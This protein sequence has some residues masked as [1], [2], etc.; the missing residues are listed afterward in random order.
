MH[1]GGI[2]YDLAKVF[3]CVNHEILPAKLP[4]Y[5][6][7]GVSEDWFRF[8]LTNKSQQVEVTSPNKLKHFVPEWGTLKYGVPQG[9]I[10]GPLLFIIY[11]NDLPLK[12]NSLPEPILFV[13]VTS[14]IISSR[15]FEYFCSVLNLGLSHMIKCF[16]ANNL[17]MNLE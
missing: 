2:Y 12:I 11:V 9:S 10:L 6:I 5:G 14:L 13:V 7:R 4:S 17:V 3:V 1:V 16:A 15:N 8:C